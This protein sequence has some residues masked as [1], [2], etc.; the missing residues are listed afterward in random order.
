MMGVD[1]EM[2]YPVGQYFPSTD[3]YNLP[4]NLTINYT[5]TYNSPVIDKGD[6]DFDR[7]GISWTSDINDR[8]LDATRLDIGA[9]YFPQTT[10]SGTISSNTTWYG[11][12]TV[13]GDV[14]V[15]SGAELII[16]PG[17]KVA[18]N[19]GK[20]L[21]V[22]GTLIAQ[23][24][25]ANHIVF[26]SSSSTPS[27]GS[28][29]GIRFEDS[30]SDVNCI[31]KYCDIQYAQYGVYCNR[32]NPRLISNTISNNDQGISGYIASPTITNNKITGNTDGVYF[33]Y[34]SPVFY[35]NS[36]SSNFFGASFYSYASPQFGPIYQGGENQEAKGFNVIKENETGII[37]RYYSEPFMGSSDP[38]GYR[39]GGYNGVYDNTA[40]GAFLEMDSHIEAEYNWWKNQ[41]TFMPYAGCSIDYIP[42]LPSDPGGGSSLGK[43]LSNIKQQNDDDTSGFNPRKPNVNRLSDLWLW[44][45]ELQ[46]THQTEEAIN[47]YQILIAKFPQSKEAKRSLVKIFHL[48]QEA[49]KSGLTEYLKGLTDGEK[50]NPELRRVAFDLL[51][52]TYLRDGNIANAVNTYD[53]ILVRYPG[54]ESE[55]LALY[56]LVLVSNTDLKNSVKAGNHLQTLKAKYPNDELALLAAREMGEKVDWSLAKRTRQP[57]AI[58][59]ILPEKFVLR[60]N[61]PNPF[62]PRT[63]IAF[64]LPEES[65]V[66]LT[67]YDIMGREIVR[68]LDENQPAGFR[69]V[70]W[71]GKDKSGQTVSSGIYLYTLKTSAGFS[72]TKKMAIVR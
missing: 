3:I 17:T 61:Y 63:T 5:P 18:F 72:E 44:A 50:T 6:P 49:E 59:Q 21:T 26:T 57:E 64:D 23:G 41:F 4:A 7:D 46:I 36:I 66:T 65:H 16:D 60:G 56:N 62:N 45:N 37:A 48:Y 31:L 39:V 24:T 19:S 1:D 69:H 28:W 27:P 30:S 55:K 25:S 35:N 34:G 2:F 20:K 8:D 29:Y 47:I 52:G 40:K 22:N 58:K 53:N 11:K 15:A 71:D 67:I 13:T 42:Y 68:L 33:Q 12:V 9:C 10:V 32:A 43:I 70:V 38:Y 54:T 14:T 51:A